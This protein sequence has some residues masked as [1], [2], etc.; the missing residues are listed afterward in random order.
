[1][2]LADACLVRM[3]EKDSQARVLTLDGAFI[4]YRK[5]TRELVPTIMSG[6]IRTRALRKIK[7]SNQAICSK[8]NTLLYVIEIP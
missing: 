2:D 8:G 3:T 6:E 1:M 7:Q 5:R 4:I